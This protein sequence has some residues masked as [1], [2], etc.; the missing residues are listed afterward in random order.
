MNSI[1]LNDILRLDNTNNV[2]IHFNF[3]NI[4]MFKL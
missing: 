1:G 2:K 3:A 4:Y